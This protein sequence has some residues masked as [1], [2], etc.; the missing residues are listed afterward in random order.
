[1]EPKDKI[2]AFSDLIQQLIADP[3]FDVVIKKEGNQ[4]EVLL[5][6][7]SKK[8]LILKKDGTWSF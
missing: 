8:P 3:R 7:N 1:M 5:N 6:D 2:P 4:L